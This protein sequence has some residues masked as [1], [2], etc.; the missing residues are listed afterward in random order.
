MELVVDF[1]DKEQKQQLYNHLKACLPLPYVVTF[2]LKRDKLSKSQR[3]YY[4]AVVIP[5]LRNY[6]GYEHLEMH[7]L[8]K[9]LHNSERKYIEQ[10]GKW[11]TIV[12]STETL[13]TAAFAE[14]LT[15]I[16]DW[17]AME[18]A[19]RIPEPSKTIVQRV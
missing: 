2:K 9:S 13:D 11:V 6:F 4:N 3:G 10:T 16:L 14:Y 1:A 7:D 12:H 19:I 18:F 17:A 15:K 5:T 8:L